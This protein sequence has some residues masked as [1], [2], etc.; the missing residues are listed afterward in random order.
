MFSCEFCEI[1]KNNFLHR[2]PHVAA[3]VVNFLTS[4]SIVAIAADGKSIKTIWFIKVIEAECLSKNAELEDYGHSTA[5]GLL[6]WKI[7][8]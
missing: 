6:I 4:G 8:F 3:S 5:K 1:S 2:T 7:A